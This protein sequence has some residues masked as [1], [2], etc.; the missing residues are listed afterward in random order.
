MI[1]RGTR[2]GQGM[3]K[4]PNTMKTNSMPLLL[5][6]IAPFAMRMTGYSPL[7]NPV[8]SDWGRLLLFSVSGKFEF[9]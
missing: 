4:I 5:A 7:T 1:L 2:V 9:W 6:S 8:Q 3:G